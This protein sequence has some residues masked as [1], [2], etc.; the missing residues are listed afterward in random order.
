MSHSFAGIRNHNQFFDVTLTTDDDEEYTDSLRA[1]KVILSACSEFFRNILTKESMCTHPNP[2]VYLRGISAQDLKYTLDFMYHGEVN[3]AR[4]ELDNFLEVAKTLKIKGLTQ[5]SGSRPSK[6][7]ASG[8][9]SSSPS[10]AEPRKK[11]KMHSSV[12]LSA[13]L[14]ADVSVKS[15]SGPVGDEDFQDNVGVEIDRGD[16]DYREEFE[17]AHEEDHDWEDDQASGSRGGG[18]SGEGSEPKNY[19]GKHLTETEKITLVN[20]IKTLDRE[21]ILRS[22]G[23]LQRD[24]ETKEKR[25]A[26]WAQI[27]PAFNEI[28]GINCDVQ[29]LKA[30]LNRIKRTT[31]WK[32]HSVLYDD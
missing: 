22:A 9:M 23:T 29:K 16:E 21:S 6:R 24:P 19:K 31:N 27:L 13:K 4:D 18:R 11:P 3:V 20:L 28:C 32:S 30:T 14:E 15:E 7:P 26:L 1:H 2:L 5:D 25:R 17:G 8:A 12:S 10:I